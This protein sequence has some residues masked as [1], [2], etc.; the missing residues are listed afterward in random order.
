MAIA[1]SASANGI[2]IDGA[3]RI[4]RKVVVED[5]AG[6]IENGVACDLLT[7]GSVTLVSATDPADECFDLSADQARAI[8]GMIGHCKAND[9]GI[10][11]IR[12]ES[13]REAK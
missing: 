6:L 8:I 1:A 5:V 3:C 7:S 9:L 12:D 4:P 2:P 11:N 13:D 10:I